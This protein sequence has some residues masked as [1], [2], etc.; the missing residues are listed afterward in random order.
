[1]LNNSFENKLSIWNSMPITIMWQQD[2]R[3]SSFFGVWASK[4]QEIQHGINISII[5]NTSVMIEGYLEEKCHQIINKIRD[6]ETPEAVRLSLIIKEDLS[7][8][9]FKNYNKIFNRLIGKKLTTMCSD[10]PEL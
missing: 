1:M 9:S 2:K 10:D 6:K 8:A 4:M 5:L 3:D 7:K